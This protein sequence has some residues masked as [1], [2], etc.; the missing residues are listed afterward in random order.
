MSP[1]GSRQA[2]LKSELLKADKHSRYKQIVGIMMYTA[3]KTRWNVCVAARM[4]GMQ[5]AESGRTQF[6]AAKWFCDTFG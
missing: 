2:A 1:R 3:V 6:L 5:V 4:F